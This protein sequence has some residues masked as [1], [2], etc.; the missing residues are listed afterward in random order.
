M[1][2][3]QS[4]SAS[5]RLCSARSQAAYQGY[6]QVS[7][8]AMTSAP[9]TCAH[10]RL[11]TGRTGPAP[12]QR[13]MDA[14]L[15]QPAGGVVVVKLLVPEHAGQSLARDQGIV[16][17]SARDRAHARIRSPV[18]TR[19]CSA[20]WEDLCVERVG[21]G[22]SR[23]QCRVEARERAAGAVRRRRRAVGKSQPQQAAFTRGQRQPVA[24]GRLGSGPLRIDRT[25][26]PADDV[27][28][29]AVLNE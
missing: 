22:A 26:G 29:D 8:M 3:A 11:R 7:G 12:R 14:M 23:R 24:R 13:A 16:G 18:R 25:L 19:A 6:S 2:K 10:A 4:T 20:G 5:G 17:R 9:A 1:A 28:V 21:L 27:V 15:G